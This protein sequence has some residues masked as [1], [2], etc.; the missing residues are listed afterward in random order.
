[1]SVSPDI[2]ET[3]PRRSRAEYRDGTDLYCAVRLITSARRALLH[4]RRDLPE[5]LVDT[6]V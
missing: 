2:K 4:H 5:S 6:Y 1:M 3:R